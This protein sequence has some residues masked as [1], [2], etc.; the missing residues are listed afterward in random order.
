MTIIKLNRIQILWLLAVLT[1]T[2]IAYYPSFN[3]NFVWDDGKY[4]YENNDFNLSGGEQFKNLCTKSY[5]SNYHPLT[6][7]SLTLDYQIGKLNPFI[8]HLTNVLFHL[9]NTALVFFFIFLLGKRINLKYYF[10]TAIITAAL[11]GVHTL[12]VESVAWVSERKDVLYT[13]SFLLSLINYLR[14]VFSQEEGSNNPRKYYIYSTLFSIASLLSKGQAVSL[15]VTL[16]VIDYLLER[17]LLSKKVIIEKIPFFILALLFGIIAI[18]VQG[19]AVNTSVTVGH[20]FGERLVFAGFGFC[21]YIVKL[22]LP[23]HLS[24]F[25]PYP[26]HISFIHYLCLFVSLLIV[27]VTVYY[28]KQYKKL[29]FGVLFFTVNIALVLQVLPVGNCIMADRYSYVPSIG[30]FFLF[31]LLYNFIANKS[32]QYKKP[33]M[34]FLAAYMLLLAG[35]TFTRVQVWKD[36]ISLWD[37]IIEKYDNIDIAYYNRGKAKQ[38]LKKY[39][40]A[41]L[42]Y[43]QAI[44]L[45]PNYYKAYNNRGNIKKLSKRYQEAILDYDRTIA[46][47]P[48]YSEAYYNRGN[49]KYLL[50]R[51][52]EAISDYNQTIVLSPTFY[53]AY[54]NR[55]NAKNILKKY[56]EAILDFNQA[57]ALNP[58][59]SEAYHNRGHTKNSIRKHQEA[60]SDFD[61]AIVLNP[62]Y[63]D[64]Y[65]NRGSTFLLLGDYDKANS[66]DLR[67]W[68]D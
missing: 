42:D 36:N 34:L 68:L 23:V 38:I 53:S 65:L 41:I 2:L 24:A 7:F 67:Q 59:Y 45:N 14:Y 13:F 60:I 31:G 40:D 49:T 58:N 51:Y 57:I 12:H 17:K 5:A 33:I 64:A 11:F 10:E 30:F 21:N 50:K 27:G 28:F 20:T 18:Y 6:M 26:D 35:I 47:N 43:D 3:N 61:Q 8:Y 66:W 16:F 52:Q 54:Y 56:Q 25:Y 62:N 63:Q 44:V 1:I 9:L 22:I 32:G 39:K 46:I 4:I 37:D 29:V 48:N 19:N 55:G 15:V